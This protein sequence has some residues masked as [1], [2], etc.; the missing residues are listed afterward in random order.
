MV[1]WLIMK[2]LFL[3]NKNIDKYTRIFKYIFFITLIINVLFFIQHHHNYLEKIKYKI[4]IQDSNNPTNYNEYA[5]IY[6]PKKG[7]S[8]GNYVCDNGG[9]ITQN[10]SK[11]ISFTGNANKCILKFDISDVSLYNVLKNEAINN[12]SAAKY[13]GEHADAYDGSGTEDI[14]Y[15]TSNDNVLEKN[16]VIFANHCWQMIRTT[17]TGGVKMIYN[18][19]PENNTCGNNRQTHIGYNGRG[20]TSLNENYYY[21]NDYIYDEEN[22]KFILSGNIVSA[23]WNATTGPT[24]IGKYTCKDISP[25]EPCSTL[26]YVESYNDATSAHTFSLNS[27]SNYSLF[28]TMQFNPSNSLSHV[29][30]M[31]NASYEYTKETAY[32]YLYGSDFTYSTSTKRYTLTNTTSTSGSISSLSDRHYTCLNSSGSCTEI[33]YIFDYYDSSIFSDDIYYIKFS[34]GKSVSDVINEMLYANDVNKNDSIIKKALDLWYQHY[35]T[36]YTRYIEDIVFCYDRTIQSLGPFN[37]NGGS[38]EEQL[39]FAGHT[40]SGDLSCNNQTDRFS[41][42]NP[43]ARLTYPVGIASMADL[44]YLNNNSRKAGGAYY[45]GTP[46]FYTSTSYNRLINSSGQFSNSSTSSKYGLRPVISLKPD[47]EYIYGNGSTLEPYII[48]EE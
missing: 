12:G 41:V 9:R 23:T 16:N 32:T 31:Y 14:Y 6:F 18:G 47:I 43:K 27:T 8:L 15:F 25:T 7:Y 38:L 40:T 30:Y 11:A 39:Y 45:I 1:S 28:G 37:P 20:T 46:Y 21:G 10:S 48:A 35:M 42:S 22:K 5:N 13:T 36:D 34:G 17:D 19:E 44:Y 4:L 2:I 3:S 33:A 29:G 26:Y 24:L